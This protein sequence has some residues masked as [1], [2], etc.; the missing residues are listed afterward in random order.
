MYYSHFLQKGFTLIELVIS[1]AILG[2]LA[3]IAIP[4]Y[5]GYILKGKMLEPQN[6]LAALRLAEEEY[7]LEKNTYFDGTD[8]NDLQTN[9][10]GLWEASKGSNGNVNFN[11]VV[12]A[13][14]TT[15]SVTATGNVVGTS[16]FGKVATMAK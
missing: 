8:T 12:S 13:S 3:G 11:Y 4:A 2:I 7:F 10:E 5:N 6:S 15:W 16:V 1:V 9:S 14:N